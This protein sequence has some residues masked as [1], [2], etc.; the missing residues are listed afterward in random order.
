MAAA[1]WFGGNAATIIATPAGVKADAPRDWSTRAAMTTS[2]PGARAPSSEPA[3]K[4]AHP[5][6]TSRLRPTRSARTPAGI[7]VPAPTMVKMLVTQLR[8]AVD[9]SG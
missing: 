7:M 8:S 6:T 2:G 9:Q 5:A 1:I 3:R 4:T